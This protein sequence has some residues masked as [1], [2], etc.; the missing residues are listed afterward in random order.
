MT[1]DDTIKHFVE[2]F[3]QQFKI[4]TIFSSNLCTI[5]KFMCIQTSRVQAIEYA[6]IYNLRF[7]SRYNDTRHTYLIRHIFLHFDIII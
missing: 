5:H 2:F 3:F 4:S 6:R 7:K 1:S